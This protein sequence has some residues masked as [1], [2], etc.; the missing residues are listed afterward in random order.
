MQQLCD[1]VMSRIGAL[2]PV[3]PVPLACA[4]IQ[5]F[6][7]D[8]IARDEL[9]ERMAEMRDTLLE[10]N[11]RVVRH[12]GGIE[13]TFERAWRMLRM[14]RVLAESGDG[15]RRAAA[16]ARAGELLREQRRALARSV[17]ACG[18]RARR[19]AGDARWARCR[20]VCS[21]EPHARLADGSHCIQYSFTH[22]VRL[23]SRP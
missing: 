7:R 9:L 15:Y 5:S 12:D 17:R 22:R 1:G 13:E 2:V 20:P 6:D 21:S 4:A 11:A 3:T 10:L 19:A 18:P 16:R 14:R 23:L 8:F